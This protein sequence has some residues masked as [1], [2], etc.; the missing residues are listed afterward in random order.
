MLDTP[1]GV[2]PCGRGVFERK[3]GRDV[4]GR[5]RGIDVRE[6]DPRVEVAGARQ[7]DRALVEERRASTVIGEVAW[8]LDSEPHVTA[9]EVEAETEESIYAHNAYAFLRRGC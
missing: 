6:Q 8:R 7:W 4:L 1:L 2:R 5:A 3:D 9:Y